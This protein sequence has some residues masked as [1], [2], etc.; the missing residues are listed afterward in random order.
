M[1]SA[2]DQPRMTS[3]QTYPTRPVRIIAP[4]VLGGANDQYVRLI[5]QWLSNRLGQPFVVENRPGGGLNIGAPQRRPLENA[6]DK[7]IRDS[8]GAMVNKT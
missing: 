1:L 6:I 5:A 2:F 3:A 7:L 4:N 8:N